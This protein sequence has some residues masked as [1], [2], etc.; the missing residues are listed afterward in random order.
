M[1]EDENRDLATGELK[2]ETSMLGEETKD[3]DIGRGH[4]VVGAALPLS[5]EACATDPTFRGEQEDGEFR[6]GKA[7]YQSYFW[8]RPDV[9]TGDDLVGAA[10]PPEPASTQ[11]CLAEP[12]SHCQEDVDP[13]SS[14]IV[15]DINLDSCAP[16][17]NS[18]AENE[19]AV[20]EDDLGSSEASESPAPLSPKTNSTAN[21][22]PLLAKKK[23]PVHTSSESP[24]QSSIADI[25]RDSIDGL[26]PEEES[27]EDCE[28]LFTIKSSPGKGLGFFATRDISQGTQI[29][30]ETPLFII[31]N[32]NNEHEIVH[33]FQALSLAQKCQFMD[34]NC[35]DSTKD[36]I[37]S[38]FKGNAFRIG[39]GMTSAVFVNASR[40]N[41]SCVPN[42]RFYFD[43]FTKRQ[44]FVAASDV[45]KGHEITICYCPPFLTCR[46]R[47]ER[48]KHYQFSCACGACTDDDGVSDRRRVR[49]RELEDLMEDDT[50]TTNTSTSGTIGGGT[51]AVRGGDDS[52]TT[53]TKNF[54][55]ILEFI[56]LMDEERLADAE[57]S[58]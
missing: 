56:H 16:E 39:S 24:P 3:E 50:N 13:N 28:P 22:S 25:K 7:F 14:D 27:Q 30:E 20:P 23:L 10:S 11:T 41:H 32:N 46:E 19:T 29:L 38:R 43:E 54:S 8:S 6:H 17:L 45:A 55:H 36:N 42:T 12:T 5:S 26:D 9:G 53:T 44:I 34:L 33:K 52:L 49:L 57:L 2:V 15:A 1:D 21:T 18:I 37:I 51:G 40:I 4:D 47:N 35:P 31:A 48:L 58:W